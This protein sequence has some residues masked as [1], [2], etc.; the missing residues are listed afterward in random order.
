M[1]LNHFV[2]TCEF[3]TTR[4]KAMKVGGFLLNY[5]SCLPFQLSLSTF[6]IMRRCHS[7]ESLA[8]SK[9]RSHLTLSP[10]Q[11]QGLFVS[12]SATDSQRLERS[13]WN[14]NIRITLQRNHIIPIVNCEIYTFHVIWYRHHHYPFSMPPWKERVGGK[15]VRGSSFKRANNSVWSNIEREWT[16]DALLWTVPCIRDTGEGDVR[17]RERGKP[18]IHSFVLLIEGQS[19]C[20][21][22]ACIAHCT[23]YFLYATTNGESRHD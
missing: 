11:S 4:E 21:L 19:T 14:T 8:L 5:S 6:S 9:V 20:S 16:I 23:T 17:E 10:S 1:P 22:S 15:S 2:F 3:G 12:H 13:R 18:S 7:A